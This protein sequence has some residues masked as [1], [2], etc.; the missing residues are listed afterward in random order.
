MVGDKERLRVE[1][2]DKFL[3]AFI[4]PLVDVYQ[5]KA[6]LLLP[7]PSNEVLDE[8]RWEF[9][10]LG[11]TFIGKI[12]EPYLC[13]SFQNGG[14]VLAPCSFTPRLHAHLCFISVQ[15]ILRIGCLVI[16]IYSW[17][18]EFSRCVCIHNLLTEECHGWEGSASCRPW[19]RAY[20]RIL[21]MSCWHPLASL[22]P[23]GGS[24]LL[25]TVMVL[26]RTT[27]RGWFLPS[28]SRVRTPSAFQMRVISPWVK[29][30]LSI[31]SS[32]PQPS[33]DN[34]LP[35]ISVTGWLR[36]FLLK[37]LGAKTRFRWWW[38]SSSRLFSFGGLSR[39]SLS[40][41]RIPS[42]S[43]GILGDKSLQS[44]MKV[45]IDLGCQLLLIMMSDRLRAIHLSMKG[46]FVRIRGLTT[47]LIWWEGWFYSVRISVA[48]SPSA[49]HDFLL[50]Y[51]HRRRQTVSV[52]KT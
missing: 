17:N 22:L 29:Y 40:L 50:T 18:L 43:E 33:V 44:V 5:M 52:I 37:R 41:L 28:M 21:L 42:A 45:L 7:L 11:D 47:L 36:G 32:F 8:Q 15:M 9:S 51:L 23:L 46:N 2:F 38:S 35:S 13:Y 14:E 34:N 6:C 20:S 25:W 4:L 26:C 12:G 1:P 16:G 49:H 24:W 39:V 48:R 10:E 3:Q 19:S 30:H 31:E 27:T